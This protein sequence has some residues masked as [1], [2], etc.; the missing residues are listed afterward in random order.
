VRCKDPKKRQ[1]HLILINFGVKK[2]KLKKH[3][4]KKKL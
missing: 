2:F 1:D 3:P 4:K